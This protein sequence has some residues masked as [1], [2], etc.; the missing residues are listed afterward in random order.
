MKQVQHLL[1]HGETL[2][3]IE[4]LVLLHVQIVIRRVTPT[5]IVVVVGRVGRILGQLVTGEVAQQWIR[6]DKWGPS[7]HKHLVFTTSD[8]WRQ[9]AVADQFDRYR[10][11]DLLHPAGDEFRDGGTKVAFG[12]GEVSE[13][14]R[15]AAIGH[16][17]HAV[18]VGV[19]V[20]GVVQHRVCLGEIEWL[21]LVQA[22]LE[23]FV[24]R[25]N[26][27]CCQQAVAA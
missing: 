7:P 24:W 6:V 26:D 12:T 21:E 19:Q 25:R 17:S 13:L 23:A 3:W 15:V 22:Q 20:A 27:G 2:R 18:V 4:F 10:D 5:G 9:L 11:A 1:D 14:Q 16:L 8:D